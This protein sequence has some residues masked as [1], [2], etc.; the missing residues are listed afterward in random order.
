MHLL[1]E[2][3][4]GKYVASHNLGGDGGALAPEAVSQVPAVP[5]A[6][7]QSK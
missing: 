3:W 7:P 6:L 4:D 5:P 2:M 1:L